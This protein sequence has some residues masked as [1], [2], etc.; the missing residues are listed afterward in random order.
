MM[1]NV[2]Q[3]IDIEDKIVGPFTAKQ[4][5]WLGI[6]GVILMIM[7][8]IVDM[9]L[10][11]VI[12]IFVAIIV[13]G[14]G[15]YRPN[16]QPLIKFIISSVFFATRPKMYVWHRVPEPDVV[17]KKAPQPINTKAAIAAHQ[18]SGEKVD[19]ISKLLD[20]TNQK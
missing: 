6:G 13:G 10:F 1:S 5:G 7:W 11:V 16:G 14:L 4:L 15:F 2:P 3:F 19:E 17:H 18:I 8:N 20:S 9:S 12:A